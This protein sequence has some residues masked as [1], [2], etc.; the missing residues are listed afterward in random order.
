MGS[1]HTKGG[2][3]AVRHQCPLLAMRAPVQPQPAPVQ[4]HGEDKRA[5][6]HVINIVI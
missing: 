1:S 6:G 3:P 2:R 5:T 4:A